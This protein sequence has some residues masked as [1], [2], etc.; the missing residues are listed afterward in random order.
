MNDNYK[1]CVL[2]TGKSLYKI[3]HETGIPYTTL[4][5][6]HNGKKNIN[7][8]AAE[9]VYK[10]CLYFNC[11]M[12]ELLNPFPLLKNSQGTYMG[13][14]YKW[15]PYLEGI[16]LHIF[17]EEDDIVLT[18]ISPAIPRWYEC[19]THEILEMLI[20]MYIKKKKAKEK[21]VDNELLM[22]INDKYYVTYKGKREYLCKNNKLNTT[23]I[24]DI[25]KTYINNQDRIER[26]DTWMTKI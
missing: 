3:A 2:K 4:N 6:L 21:L 12:N 19:Y 9:T 15:E 1:K 26:L 25:M 13:I 10:L 8:V 17:D 23:Y 11:N 24:N 5:E 16:E 14:K 22:I 7:N 18:Q 20:E